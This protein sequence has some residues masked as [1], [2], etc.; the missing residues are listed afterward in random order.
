MNEIAR[1]DH[2]G[3]QPDLFDS[4]RLPAIK[5]VTRGLE[6][7]DE[8]FAD[9]HDKNPHVYV[10]FCR[11]ARAAKSRGRTKLGIQMLAEAL[12]WDYTVNTSRDEGDFKINNNY[13]SRYARKIMANEPDL[14][15]IFETRELKT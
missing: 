8:K 6:T 3:G 7:T 14:A 13:L 10:A 9:F 4:A 5:P 1:T 2:D 12:R 15:S 11:M